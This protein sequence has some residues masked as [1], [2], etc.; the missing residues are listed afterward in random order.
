MKL[1]YRLLCLAALAIP[2]GCGGGGSNPTV[3]P[4]EN[5]LRIG[6]LF[7]LTGNWNT[8][9]RASK[10]A[11]ELAQE[12]VNAYLEER[13]SLTRVRV[14][15]AD[16]KLEPGR[17][18]TEM[19]RLGDNGATVFIGPQSSAEV[20]AVKAAAD[21]SGTLVI[22]Q[23]ST[24]SALSIAD[25]YVFR[26]VPDDVREAAALVA[27]LEEDGVKAI[28]PVA[29]D[30]S[31][32]GGLYTSTRTAFIAAGGSV[33]AGVRYGTTVTDF[34]A[35]LATVRA[36]VETLRA[37]HADAEVAIYLAAF[38][39]AADILAAAKDDAVLATVKWYGSDG[40]AL[41]AALTEN[42]NA[43]TFAATAGYP[44]PIF[45]LDDADEDTWGPVAA[46]IKAR[47]G[48][49][50]D[51]FA[52]SAYDAVWLA[53]LAHEAPGA[54]VSPAAYRA[55]FKAEA[56]DYVGVTGS[57][58]LAA[59]GDRDAG[60]FDFWSIVSSGAT[61]QWKRTAIYKAADGS[62]IRTP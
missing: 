61:F 59:T 22:S 32:N 20:A 19:D 54:N 40:V 51:A 45:G 24:S 5:E 56:D 37:T 31:G 15:V 7:S 34:T 43:A 2:L 36:Q 52:L 21:A 4:T 47:S 18:L 41:S 26:L 55:A 38:D 6:G 14:D 1:S 30:D 10:A 53:A 58:K 17:A 60:N 44:N 27:L 33:S 39:E 9:G 29:R 23:G 28:V 49:D 16:T 3:P 57:T 35:T 11:V 25:D 42:E 48:V 13:G 62:I 8:L 46:R 50:A 12:D